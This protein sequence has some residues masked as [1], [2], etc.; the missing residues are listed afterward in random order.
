M[1]TFEE[2][3]KRVNGEEQSEI[4]YPK[5][6]VVEDLKVRNQNN[7]STIAGE[8]YGSKFSYDKTFKMFDDYKRGY[9]EL[10]GHE[11]KPIIISAPSTIS[12]VNAFYGAMNAGK[13]AFPVSAGFLNAFTEQFTKG[14]GCDTVFIYDGF[15]TEDLINKLHASGVKNVIITSITDYMSPVVKFIGAKK[16]LVSPQDFL[17]E[18]VKSGKHLPSD[19]Q[20]IRLKD[21]A[22]V[23]AKSK[24]QTTKEYQEDEIGMYILTGATTSRTP[25]CVKVY[26]D[27]F[28]KM[29]EI[30]KKTWFD[31]KP[32]DRNAVFIP[33]FY[34]TG[35]IHGIHAGLF[36]GSTNIYLPKYDR[37]A[38]GKDLKSSKAKIAL[39]APSHVATLDEC[40]VKDNELN[41]VKYIFIGGEAVTPE[42]MKKYR[43][44]GIK[45]LGIESLYQGYGMTET[46]SMTSLSPKSSTG[47]DVSVE[48]LP[49]MKFRIVDPKTGVE[50]PD[51]E[52][53][54]VEMYSPCKM[55]GYLDESLNEQIFT[56]D[57][58]IHTG[59]IG[60]RYPNGYYRVFGRY[61]DSFVN[62][63][64]T[65]FL[66]DIEE[67]VLKHPGVLEAEVIK[68]N[69]NGEEKPAIVV[70]AKQE[71]Q[72]RLDEILKYINSINIPGLELSIGTRFIDYF[73]TNP[74]TA[75][76]DYLSLP[77]YKDGYYSLDGE[78]YMQTDIDEQGQIN[79][80]PVA[81]DEIII[82]SDEPLQRKLK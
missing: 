75:K 11:E 53:G 71:W 37:F 73:K 66:F 62:N 29:A 82:R 81:K 78:T 77:D 20:F 41:H 70:V 10:E 24:D 28:V 54:I 46:A 17:D 40:D 27:G 74:V 31:F 12:S 3:Q 4:E 8:Y 44:G 80:Y 35:I 5:R 56:E 38:F 1:E 72:N 15:L 9:Y 60:V 23:G 30:Y 48:P 22:K 76:R 68:F 63:D 52:R 19:M 59:D 25:K 42:Q 39:V 33:I 64:K 7:G 45:R 61:S 67:E 49:G 13:I 43:E 65:Y 50:L 47:D 34:G 26:S 21:F 32:G 18:Y 6:R 55:A 58:W 16:S 36:S 51:G 57:G 2:F 79:K 14:V 69:I